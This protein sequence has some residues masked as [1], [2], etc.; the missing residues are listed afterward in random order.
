[1]LCCILGAVTV[2]GLF[3]WNRLR[4]VWPAIVAGASAVTFAGLIA[5][6]IA[7]GHTAMQPGGALV[8]NLPICTS[9]TII[10]Q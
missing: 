5:A 1:M 8:Q 4:S 3:V 6:H 9:L 7:A 10:S 2:A